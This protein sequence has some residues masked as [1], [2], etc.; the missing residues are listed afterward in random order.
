[1]PSTASCSKRSVFARSRL[2]RSTMVTSSL[3]RLRLERPGITNYELLPQ[4]DI[5]RLLLSAISQD[6]VSQVQSVRFIRCRCSTST[7]GAGDNH[8]ARCRQA[9]HANAFQ[10]SLAEVA[11]THNDTA[12]LVDYGNLLQQFTEFRAFARTLA[13]FDLD[14]AHAACGG[15]RS[16]KQYQP[17]SKR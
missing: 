14:V 3:R 9:L 1:M 15:L 16:E 17:I 11:Q 4:T 8:V 12:N 6:A 13:F 5:C 7:R 10:Y 2:R